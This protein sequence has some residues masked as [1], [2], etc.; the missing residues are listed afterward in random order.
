MCR[1][2]IGL[3][4]TL[5]E[6][7]SHQISLHETH[8][9]LDFAL[10]MLSVLAFLIKRPAVGKGQQ[11][12]LVFFNRIKVAGVTSIAIFSK[13][14]FLKMVGSI[15]SRWLLTYTKSLF[16]YDLN[17]WG[18]L[19]LRTPPKIN[20][21]GPWAKTSQHISHYKVHYLRFCQ[22]TFQQ[23]RSIQQLL[24]PLKF[25]YPKI[26]IHM[27]VSIN[28]STPIAGWFTMENPTK[29]DDLGVSQF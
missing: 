4:W 26:Q 24:L 10:S 19:W 14:R 12:P 21:C 8:E 27:G 6:N 5:E 9:I 2:T 15:T 20:S 17:D 11:N 22:Q 7:S 25:A 3:G 18:V 28:G 13:W 1:K 16:I 29:M 23:N